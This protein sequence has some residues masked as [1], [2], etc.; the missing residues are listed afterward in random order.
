M[1]IELYKF[2]KLANCEDLDKIKDI[3]ENG[4]Y[5]S[6]FL[7]FNDMNEGVFYAN[8]KDKNKNKM[9]K[10]RL[11]TILSEKTK[12][13]ICSFSRESALDS[14]LMWGHYANAGMGIAIEIEDD[15]CKNME[16]VVYSD[17]YKNL[18]TIKKILTHKTTE[19]KYEKEC[20]YLS[21]DNKKYVKI[22]V[23]TKIYFGT[24]YKELGN[25][26][27]IEE[28]HPKLNEYLECKK[29]LKKYLDCEKKYL[30]NHNSG[31]DCEKISYE[32]YKFSK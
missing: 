20:R 31:T 3:I 28:K 17:S 15:N 21:K 14:Q 24:P 26:G 5:C 22:G 29:E 19:W 23:I 16:K 7:D 11:N 9:L 1:K 32:D 4:F 18:N 6:N 30:E 25:Y 13:K 27:D 2:R 8:P 12:Y 10:T